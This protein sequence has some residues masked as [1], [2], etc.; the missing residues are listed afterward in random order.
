METKRTSRGSILIQ[1]E[2]T[3]NYYPYNEEV[4]KRLEETYKKNPEYYSK[5]V[6]TCKVGYGDFEV[7][8]SYHAHDI[9]YDPTT[10]M[11]D[12]Y[13]LAGY[14][15]LTWVGALDMMHHFVPATNQ[16]NNFKSRKWNKH[17]RK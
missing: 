10:H 17:R 16:S 9:S 3:K 14:C 4:V 11:P 2:Y 12:W 8:V 1:G 6:F 7:G 5:T 15:T 13:E